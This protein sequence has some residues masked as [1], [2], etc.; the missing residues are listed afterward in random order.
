MTGKSSDLGPRISHLDCATA[1]SSAVVPDSGY[2]TSLVPFALRGLNRT[3]W[4]CLAGD[5]TGISW[6]LGWYVAKD[7][8]PSSNTEAKG[9]VLTG[10]MTWV[11]LVGSCDLMT[12]RTWSLTSSGL[13]R[14]S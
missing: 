10:L 8:G 11:L 4:K 6:W 12:W 2:N 3:I 1:W 14:G 5:S 13:A 7:M 9:C